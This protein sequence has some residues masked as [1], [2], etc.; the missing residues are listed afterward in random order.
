M[1]MKKYLLAATM[2]ACLAN[3]ASTA[4][5]AAPLSEEQLVS[6]L[7]QLAGRGDAEA[8]YHLGM[9]YNN[10]IGVPKDPQRAY[11]SFAAAA[12][13][14]D[15]LAAYKVGCYL[16][17][18]FPGAVPPDAEQA[19]AQKLRAAEA[20]YALAQSDVAAIYLQRS[21]PAEG[22]RWMQR[23]ADQGYPQALFNLSV[24]HV[25]GLWPEADPALGYAYFKLAKL[26]SEGELNARA[27]ASLDEL[28]QSLSPEQMKRAEALAASW[29]ANPSELT[30]KA[31]GG[32]AAAH[33]LA[34]R[35]N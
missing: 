24:G 30:I 33:S 34:A 17:G 29:R 8:N 18:Q 35:A 28:K 15:A 11:R 14:G 20:G 2:L 7:Q 26:A 10:G 3:A 21:M 5:M 19:L 22:Q 23:A 31:R 32:L 12:A 16:A 13:A 1:K 25:K 9:L 27:K 4:A 6:R